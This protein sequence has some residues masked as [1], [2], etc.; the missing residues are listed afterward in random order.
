MRR[1]EEDKKQDRDE[2]ERG[3][4]EELRMYAWKEMKGKGNERGQVEGSIFL[5]IFLNGKEELRRDDVDKIGFGDFRLNMLKIVKGVNNRED[6]VLLG[7]D[8][9]LAKDKSNKSDENGVYKV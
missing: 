2:W 6:G 5:D 1:E 7:V 8:G 9:V 4:R 3:K